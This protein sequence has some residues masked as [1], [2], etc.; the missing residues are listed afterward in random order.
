VSAGQQRLARLFSEQSD[1]C[2]R[3]GSPLYAGLLAH[4]AKDIETGG[5]LADVLAGHEQDPGPSALALRLAGAVHRLVLEGRAPEL[6]R[7]YPSVGGT[8]LVDPAWEAFRR[9]VAENQPTVRTL[10]QSPPQTN[11]VGRSAILFGGLLH[12]AATTGLP[13]RLLDIGASAGLNLLVDQFRFELTERIALGDATSPVQ[14]RQPWTADT[15]WPPIEVPLQIVERRGCDVHPVDALTG[16]GRVRLTSYVWPDQLDRIDRLR[17]A[18]AVAERTPVAV[19]SACASDFLGRHLEFPRQG[20]ATVVW[21][22]VVWQYLDRRERGLVER[23]LA[24]AASM[25]THDAP[26][27]LLSFEPRRVEYGDWFAFLAALTVWPGGTERVIA[28]GQ[29]HGPPVTWL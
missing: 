28:E 27:A 11:E 22:S 10:L 17:G 13:I 18:F 6:A 19:E 29:G 2:A 8:A 25:A 1:G 9:T 24:R 23:T 26:L 20:V 15:P 16:E 7:Y 12:V 14:L 3:L 4:A 5:V 21:H